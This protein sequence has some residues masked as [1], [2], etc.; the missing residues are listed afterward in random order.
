MPKKLGLDKLGLDK[1]LTDYIVQTVQIQELYNKAY[2]DEISGFGIRLMKTLDR[3]SKEAMNIAMALLPK[4]IHVDQ[5]EY[6]F[7]IH[8]E[9]KKKISGGLTFKLFCI[10]V[11]S[12]NAFLQ[13]NKSSTVRMNIQIKQ[14]LITFKNFQHG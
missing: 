6:D 13:K 4:R 8:L 7:Q 5:L 9:T 2:E 1:L 3:P 12:A 14:Q 11:V 10:P